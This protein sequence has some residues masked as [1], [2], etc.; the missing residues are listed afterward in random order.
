MRL[1]LLLTL[2]AFQPC[3]AQEKLTTVYLPT[4]ESLAT[5]QTPG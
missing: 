3:L 4:E 1:T 5:R 2:L